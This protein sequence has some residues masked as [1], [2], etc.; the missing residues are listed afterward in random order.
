M[1]NT[2]VIMDLFTQV[3]SAEDMV[4]ST[5]SK[6]SQKGVH[7]FKKNKQTNKQ[8]TR[9]A[10]CRSVL[11]VT[12][13][14]GLYGEARGSSRSPGH[15]ESI[16]FSIYHYLKFEAASICFVMDQGRRKTQQNSRIR[17]H[18]DKTVL[19]CI[20]LKKLVRL[21]QIVGRSAKERIL[22]MSAESLPL[23]LLI[24]ERL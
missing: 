9:K 11:N 4:K 17:M 12:P 16:I 20:K 19:P 23:S 3:K 5:A 7:F 8:K 10:L 1:R 13:Y 14:V 18:R 22:K 6:L 24:Y 21:I 15:G 2:S